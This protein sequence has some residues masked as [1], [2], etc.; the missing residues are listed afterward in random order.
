MLESAAET[1]VRGPPEEGSDDDENVGEGVSESGK[2]SKRTCFP[3]IVE[4]K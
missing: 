1:G 2:A 3:G 4:V